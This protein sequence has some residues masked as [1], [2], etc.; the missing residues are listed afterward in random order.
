MTDIPSTWPDNYVELI[1]QQIPSHYEQKVWPEYGKL[2]FEIWGVVFDMKKNLVTILNSPE[3]KQDPKREINELNEEI[4]EQLIQ[5]LKNLPDYEWSR[6]QEV[7]ENWELE[8]VKTKPV[9]FQKQKFEIQVNESKYALYEKWW[10]LLYFVE[11]NWDKYFNVDWVRKWVAGW[12]IES[13]IELFFWWKQVLEEWVY[14]IYIW[15][16]KVDINSEEYR[17]ILLICWAEQ[18]LLLKELKELYKQKI[19]ETLSK[20][21]DN[22]QIESAIETWTIKTFEIPWSEKIAISLNW[23]NIDYIYNLDWTEYFDFQWRRNDYMRYGIFKTTLQKKWFEEKEVWWKYF[24]YRN[25]KHISNFSEEYLTWYLETADFTKEIGQTLSDIA[26]E[27]ERENK[28]SWELIWEEKEQFITK[29]QELP[30]YEWSKVKEAIEKQTI[31][32]KKIPW[33]D[34]YAVY[35]SKVWNLVFI[36]RLDWTWYTN[37]DYFRQRPFYEDWIKSWYLRQWYWKIELINW[38]WKL[39]NKDWK[40]VHMYSDEYM[41]ATLNAIN[42]MWDVKYALDKEIKRR[43]WD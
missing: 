22:K 5:N 6:L 36:T 9:S 14:N 4:V 39:Y 42:T 18:I 10:N 28:T 35:E 31:E 7:V 2:S 13:W 12:W 1:E 38:L 34:G 43:K 41:V 24:L 27:M 23:N 32:I 8:I 16:R 3:V 25:N 19:S 37:V 20:I 11:L 21:K 29:L 17:E 40:E 30:D 33:R 26:T 15:D